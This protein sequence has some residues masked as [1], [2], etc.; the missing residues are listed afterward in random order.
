[1]SLS[2]PAG[3]TGPAATAYVRALLDLLGE[4]SARDVLSEQ[5]GV[6]RQLTAGRGDHDLRRPEAPGKWSVVQVVQ[7]QA[8]TELVFGFRLRM[9][10][11][12]ER[13]ALAAYD[14]DLWAEKLLYAEVALED[15]LD[16]FTALR[17]SNLALLA[18]QPDAA[19]DRVG[20]H[21]ERGEESARHLANLAAGHDLAHRR[22]VQRILASG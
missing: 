14:Q 5:P 9:V 21:A 1:M 22:Q 3:S 10:L 17:R 18:R 7:H 20:L 6:L 11:A 8:D 15:A 4:R 19:L 12:H 13:P 2:N 16:Q